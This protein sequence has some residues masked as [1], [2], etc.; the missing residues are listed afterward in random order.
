MPAAAN[1][2]KTLTTSDAAPAAPAMPGGEAFAAMLSGTEPAAADATA[3]QEATGLAE[4]T[5]EAQPNLDILAP[6]LAQQQV[7]P[8]VTVPQPGGEGAAVEGSASPGVV[9]ILGTTPASPLVPSEVEGRVNGAPSPHAANTAPATTVGLDQIPTG[10]PDSGR[11]EVVAQPHGA[12][13][14]EAVAGDV[15]TALTEIT[16][17][18]GKTDAPAHQPAT[19][20]PVSTATAT[21]AGD[22]QPGGNRQ[23]A[24]APVPTIEAQAQQP[25]S[26][27]TDVRSLIASLTG[28]GVTGAGGPGQA[29]AAQ[30]LGQALAAQVLDLAGGSAWLEQLS[31]EIGRAADGSGPLRFRLTP[32]SLGELKVE[33]SQSD[34]G[35][36]VRMTVATEAA[37]AALAD[38]QPRLAAEARAQGV[39]IAETQVDLAGNQAQQQ[40]GRE[41]ARQQAAAADQ[42]LRAFRSTSSGPA[43][44]QAGTATSRPAERY[45]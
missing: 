42:P 22:Q 30:Q 1:P 27:V 4:T 16:K 31:D 33:I 10:N 7:V 45:A 2:T 13:A 20:T 39:R 23:P 3:A 37:Q 40:Q 15:K 18:P 6:L 26:T 17:A 44:T 12:E 8:T 38:A 36:V 9:Q 41:S 25:T 24:E 32:E 5:A 35:A 28:T 19:T 21:G 11:A 14:S 34:R 43:G 29:G